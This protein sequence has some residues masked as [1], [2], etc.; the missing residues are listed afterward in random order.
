MQQIFSNI[1]NTY[2]KSKEFFM[3]IIPIVIGILVVVAVIK[4]FVLAFQLLFGIIILPFRILGA[5]L[6]AI[7]TLLIVFVIF[8]TGLLGIII[9]L[10]TLF[11]PL[12]VIGILILAAIK[13]L[14]Q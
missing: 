4:I 1:V 10:T 3:E 7:I 5:F 11:A 8:S 6:G 2:T 12:L 13:F 9:S 14:F